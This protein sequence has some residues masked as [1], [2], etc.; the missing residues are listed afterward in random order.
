MAQLDSSELAYASYSRLLSVFVS[1]LFLILE[2]KPEPRN[3]DY[4]VHVCQMSIV[5]QEAETM[6][7]KPHIALVKTITWT[8]S[9]SMEWGGRGCQCAGGGDDELPN[10]NKCYNSYPTFTA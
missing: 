9:K 8:G 5:Q 7:L 2:T 3:S 1:A 4:M 10:R 6:I